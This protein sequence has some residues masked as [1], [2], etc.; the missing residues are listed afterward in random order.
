MTL[1]LG[2]VDARE[3]AG[4]PG[5]CTVRANRQTA[6]QLGDT[7]VPMSIDTQC[8]SPR[9][10]VPSETLLTILCACLALVFMVVVPASAEAAPGLQ[11]GVRPWL[12]EGQRAFVRLP[13][14]ETVAVTA[15]A[16][17][18]QGFIWF[19]TQ[20]NLLRW[21]GYRLRTYARNPDAPG[22]LPDNFIRSLLVDDSG[23]VW[24]GTNA[25]GLSRYDAQLDGFVSMPVGPGGTRDGT[26]SALISDGH[27]GLWVGTGHGIDH[28]NGVTRRID[29][30]DAK[31]PTDPIVALLLDH[32]GTLWAGTRHGLLRRRAGEAQFQTFALPTPHGT[33]PLIRLLHEDRGGRI[34]VGLDLLGVYILDPG[35]DT[36][37]RLLEV[38]KA[39]KAFLESISALCEID[40]SEVW[41]GTSEG[42]IA[43]VDT[44]TWK[45]ERERRDPLR[46]SSLP[47]NQIDSMFVDRTGT[48]WIG[49]RTALSRI[50]PR[51]RLMQTFYGSAAGTGLIRGE[52]VSS[53]LALPD[54]RLWMGLVGGGVEIVDP[55]IGETGIIESKAGDFATALPK[56]QVVTMARW[57]DGDIFL[58]TAAGLYRAS[59]DGRSVRRVRVPGR[60]A[61]F[62]VRALLAD[63]GHLWMGGLEGLAEL[64]VLKDGKVTVLRNWEKEF[65]D[66]RVRALARSD[67][68]GVW[69]GTMSGVAHLDIA[70][71]EITRLPNDPRN[72]VML[73]GGYIS[74]ML[75]DQKGRLWV[76]TFGRGIQVEQQ[77]DIKG[78]RVF[79]RLT[80]DDGLPDNSVDALVQDRYGNTWVSTDGGLARIEPEGLRI[81]R[82]RPE[83]GVGLDGFF[84]GDAARTSAGEILFGGSN[85]LV[86][87]HPD[88]VAPD[89]EEPAIA[90]TDLR[91]GGQ[92][93]APS[94]ALLGDG[95]SIGT[96]NRSLAIE[97]AAPDFTDAERRRY[98]YR[99]RGFDKSWVETTV[100]RRLATYTNLPPGDYTLQLRSAEPGATWSAP[101]DVPLHVRPTW[102]EYRS[103]RVLAVLLALVLVAA[104]VHIRTHILRV[105]QRDLERIVAQR[106]S[107]LLRQQEM[108]ERMAYLDPLTGLPNRRSF[109]D[110]LCRMIAGAGRGH[111]NVVLLTV[112][113]DGF[114]SI[115]DSLGHDAGDTVLAEVA[116]RLRLLVRA[117]D[118]VS[119][120]GGDEFGVIL[121]QP[122]DDAAVEATCARILERLSQPIR[123]GEQ[124]VV[125]GASIGVA[126]TDEFP[127]TL[128]ELC[129][130]ADIAL[131]EAK[132]AGRNTWRWSARARRALE[133][134]E[135]LQ[136]ESPGQI[137]TRRA[138]GSNG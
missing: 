94:E 42:G 24:V 22:S 77:H 48:L 115:N 37:R 121:A 23:R 84:T 82:F 54:G 20:S 117:T 106:T 136:D 32:A 86:V 111:G 123:V 131:Y 53:L 107:E 98:G 112:D 138:S 39:G 75:T 76:A 13:S 93:V 18:A 113:L 67:D 135:A 25:G 126:T 71:Q 116:Q 11:P 81:R 120:L 15:M 31:G 12:L 79:R 1:V 34:W 109:N 40:E 51:Q 73:P 119:R 27:D 57:D 103:A 9:G 63:G 41:L 132:R 14:A 110:D 2:A 28:L 114:K 74:S 85:G 56:S 21:D 45:V 46:A 72:P 129:K 7:P 66:P 95:I 33:A 133:G 118:R 44:R 6:A 134:A 8:P 64:A 59:P 43:R 49:T 128:E 130:A 97:F 62:D 70:T 36:P 104:L 99:L 55:T 69:I 5:T 122:R 80:R 90:I 17:D 58:G 102:Y 92:N 105:R 47:S 91:V 35:S 10:F 101:L 29:S 125:P 137:V 38:P 65:G 100:S 88:Q 60:S 19:G 83:Q 30:A 124:S 16:Q 68:A 52:A 3:S 61:T 87:V 108:L 127:T 26:I 89:G 4:M 78:G 50:N 96:M